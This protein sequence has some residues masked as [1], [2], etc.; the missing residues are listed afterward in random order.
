ML[1]KRRDELRLQSSR[2]EIVILL[3]GGTQQIGDEKGRG[4][5]MLACL[6][7]SH[8]ETNM[9]QRLMINPTPQCPLFD[10]KARDTDIYQ[11]LGKIYLYVNITLP[12]ISYI[13]FTAGR[14]TWVC[15]HK[16]VTF[17]RISIILI[18]GL[19]TARD[20]KYIYS[21]IL[22]QTFISIL[23]SMPR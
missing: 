17:F 23:I 7:A 8:W 16:D 19:P 12:L 20:S 5:W 22:C 14:N 1:I 4:P 11:I 15:L 18:I 13:S 3:W 10:F 21:Y 6:E 9:P 2:Y